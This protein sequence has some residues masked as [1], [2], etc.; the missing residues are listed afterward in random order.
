[1]PTRDLGLI[2]GEPIIT[3]KRYLSGGNAPAF[4]GAEVLP[5][6]GMML[7]QVSAHLP[8]RGP[9]NILTAPP[10]ERGQSVIQYGSRYFGPLR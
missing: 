7:L 4:V 3:L 5:G 8:A 1:M 9:F 2:G 6:R 10:V